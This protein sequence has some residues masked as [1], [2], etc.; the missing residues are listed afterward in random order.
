MEIV[1]NI[2]YGGQ[3]IAQETIAPHIRKLRKKL[4]EN[5]EPHIQI[6]LAKVKIYLFFNGALTSYY[7]ETGLYQTTYYNKKEEFKLNICLHTDLWT[8]DQKENLRIFLSTFRINF[9]ES[10]SLLGDKLKKIK[11]E[12]NKDEVISIFDDTLNNYLD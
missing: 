1:V 3:N 6:G 7:Q 2:A 10:I 9:T 4:K 8:E 5:F 12:F 11:V